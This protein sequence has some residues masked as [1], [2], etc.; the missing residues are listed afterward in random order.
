METTNMTASTSSYVFDGFETA[1]KQQEINRLNRKTTIL[2]TIDRYACEQIGLRPAMTVL[3]LG[4]GSGTLTHELARAV[5][6]GKTLGLDASTEMIAYASSNP[7]QENVQFR[8]GNVYDLAFPEATFDRVYARFLF[9]HLTAPLRALDN[10][11]RVLK[12]GGKLCVVDVDDDWFTLYPAPAS[13]QVFREQIL[14]IQ[15]AEGG[16]PYVGRKLYS[17]LNDAKLQNTRS[18][19][20]I[21]GSDEYGTETLLDLLSFGAPYHEK[22]PQFSQVA[23]QAKQDIYSLINEREI[24]SSFG[25]FVATGVKSSLKVG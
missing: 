11:Y 25:I 12:P 24:W 8:V 7:S 20:Q 16:D 10:I 17:Y 23:K 6:P 14:A 18:S 2:Q 9:Q 22:Y 19:I 21:I 4:C 5:Y 15:Q 13:F 3:D 1:Y